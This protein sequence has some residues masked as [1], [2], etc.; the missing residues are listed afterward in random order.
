MSQKHKIH[1]QNSE[2]GAALIEFATCLPFFFILLF[3]CIDF[4]HIFVQRAYLAEA[5]RAEGRRLEVAEDLGTNV[6]SC[7]ALKNK[8]YTDLHDFIP[9]INK[10]QTKLITNLGPLNQN[11][12]EIRLNE[13]RLSCLTCNIPFMPLGNIAKYNNSFQFPIE[14]HSPLLKYSSVLSKC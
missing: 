6:N 13:H 1:N 8:I 3:A 4:S 5:V 10:L 12:L 14:D 9:D 11:F 2:S 7:N